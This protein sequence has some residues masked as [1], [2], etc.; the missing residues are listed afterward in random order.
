M[1]RITLK[2]GACREYAEPVA[3]GRVA[4]DISPG[5][6]RTALAAEIDGNVRDLSAVIEN[7]CALK[8]LTFDD[9]GGRLAFRHT[10]ANSAASWTCSIYTRKGP[11]SPSSCP[12]A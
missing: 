12:R 10:T 5:L 9:A 7:D 6:A 1:I 11:D 8:F 2:D 3:A 4:A